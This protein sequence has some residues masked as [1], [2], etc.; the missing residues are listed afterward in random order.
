[1]K[2]VDLNYCMSSFLTLRYVEDTNTLFKEGME[3]I[4]VRSL[5]YTGDKFGCKTSEDI[6]LAI[7]ANFDKLKGKKLG[8][9]LSGGMDSAILAAYMPK[10]SKAY[11]FQTNLEGVIDETAVAKRYADIYGLD[12]HIIDITWEE[13]NKQVLECMKRKGAPVHSIEPQLY[14]AA[15]QA[16]RDNIDILIIGE[17][18]D[19]IFGGMD[20]LLSQDWGLDQWKERYT[21]VEPKKVLKDPVSMDYIFERYKID[22]VDKVDFQRFLDE[23]F[24][25][26]SS[27]SYQNAFNASDMDFLDPYA[28]LY[29][30]EALDLQK[31][32]NGQSKYLVRDL[33]AMKYPGIEVPNKIP[34]PRAV[35][36]WLAN[37]EGPKGDKFLPN[38]IEGMTGDQKWLIYCLELFLKT[39]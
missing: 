6:D 20:K 12:H 14:I 8:I 28:N 16:K 21:F 24:S 27:S 4:D 35:N 34:M 29:M 37:W 33:F 36:Q 38:C 5:S 13:V 2:K 10:G 26:E 7:K 18:A 31:V 39:L 3:H 11:T 22:G 25:I 1:M 23:I 9:M 30:T 15:L 19:L 32:R 17:S